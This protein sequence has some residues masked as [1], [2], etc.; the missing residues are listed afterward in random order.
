M[1][2]L[3]FWLMEGP[4]TLR[5]ATLFV[6]AAL[7][8]VLLHWALYHT[9][10]AVGRRAPAVL[11][12]DGA[13]LRHSRAPMRLLFPLFATY[14]VLPGWSRALPDEAVPIIQR[15]WSILLILAVA[16]LFIGLSCVVEAV[17][18]RRYDLG[19]ADNLH[20]RKIRTQTGILRRILSIGIAVLALSAILLQFEEFRVIGTGIL[21]SAGV[22]GVVVG[23]AAQR[24]I[25]NLLAGI[26][27]A[28]T[29][30]IRVDDVVIVEEEWGRIEEITL[31]YV[32]VRIW[33]LRRLVLPI[34]HFVEKPFQNWTRTSAEVLGTVFIHTDYTVPVDA[35]RAELLRIVQQSA[36]W[37]GQACQL[38]MTDATERTVQLRAVVSAANASE[39]WD[40]RCEVREQLIE[41]IR[42]QFPDSLPRVRAQL[43]P[44]PDS[45][46]DGD[47]APDAAHPPELRGVLV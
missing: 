21:A 1:D 4:L 10:A 27:I 34:S 37:N 7:L 17:V 19:T 22:L 35:V 42:E 15:T 5:A 40:L 31:T 20:A 30:P 29:Q 8:G 26:Q 46:G 44:L 6:G 45:R 14:L 24:P 3:R 18:T 43:T 38:Q 32:V 33:D 28:L 9:I 25:G 11:V 12:F 47:R 13:L 36:H 16:W 41:F 23:V 39:A 2:A